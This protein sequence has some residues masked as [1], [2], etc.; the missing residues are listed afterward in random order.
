MKFIGYWVLHK[1]SATSECQNSVNTGTWCDCTFG[2][3]VFGP[4]STDVCTTEWLLMR[5]I[6]HWLTVNTY[7]YG[8]LGIGYLPQTWPPFGCQWMIN[9]VNTCIALKSFNFWVLGFWLCISPPLQA[10][11]SGWCWVSIADTM[12]FALTPLIIQSISQYLIPNT[13]CIMNM[14]T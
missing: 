11:R 12:W 6:Y 5:N 7:E 4:E 1:S 10:P 14:A 2:Y 9:S 13:P 8:W 3:W